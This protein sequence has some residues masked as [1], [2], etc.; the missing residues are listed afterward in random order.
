MNLIP[1]LS[2][3]LTVELLIH[4][5]MGTTKYAAGRKPKAQPA[6]TTTTTTRGGLRAV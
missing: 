5:A 3:I 2:L 6:T 1:A 4:A